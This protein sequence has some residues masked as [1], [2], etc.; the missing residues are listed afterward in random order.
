M[1]A[2][3]DP[4]LCVQHPSFL[5]TAPRGG[6]TTAGAENIHETHVQ[7][8]PCISPPSSAAWRKEESVHPGVFLVCARGDRPKGSYSQT[9]RTSGPISRCTSHTT[10]PPTLRAKNREAVLQ[11]GKENE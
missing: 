5:A 1:L 7:R 10:K 3:D 11:V 2:E 9:K 4:R 8:V 6:E